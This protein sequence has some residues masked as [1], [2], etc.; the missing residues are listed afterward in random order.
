[1]NMNK[2][3]EPSELII[4]ENGSI[5][6]L[7][8]LPEDIADTILLVGDPGRV[9]LIASFFDKVEVEKRNREF[10]TKTG[11]YQG[12]RISVLA[13]GIGTD[14]IDIVINELDAL[15][16]IDLNTRMVKEEKRSLNFIRIGTSGAL[17]ADLPVHSYLLS[18]KGMGFDG[19][20]N[21][22][23]NR[24]K[25]SDNALEAA[26]MQHTQWSPKLTA[27]YVVPGSADLIEK[28]KSE[29][30]TAGVTISAPGF[31]GP[32]GRM[33]RLKTQDTGLN[34]KITSF[35]FEGQ[36]IT[37]YEMECS[38][39]YGL[40]AMLGHHAATIC[41]IIANRLRGEF[42]GDYKPHMKQLV[43]YVLNKVTNN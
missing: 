4:N 12:K 25:V 31:Y 35:A 18:E 13:T 42:G 23:A 40:S 3:I 22:Y 36:K 24:E 43:Q 26:F 39:L 27:P 15:V 16:N 38:A 21:F 8:L 20:L 14:N 32:Q 6:H 5:F 41:L 29:H 33:L 19:L 28:L 37:N 17:Q 7:N 30:T 9:D 10:I 34:E 1:M 2:A 11:T